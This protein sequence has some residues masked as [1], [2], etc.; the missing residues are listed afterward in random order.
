MTFVGPPAADLKSDPESSLST[1]L[2]AGKVSPGSLYLFSPCPLDN[3]ITIFRIRSHGSR[4]TH[5]LRG[6]FQCR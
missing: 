4:P 2:S 5:Q 3:A 6:T 1:F